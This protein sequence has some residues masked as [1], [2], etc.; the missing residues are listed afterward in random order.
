[1]G[2]TPAGQTR[3]RIYQF[4][5][6]RLLRG[7]PPT[8]REVR[9]AFGFRSIQ[10]AREHLEAL[11]A[12]GRLAKEKGK[13]RGYRL[14]SESGLTHL[15]PL[16]GRVPA[17]PLDLATED[18]EGYLPIQSHRPAD[19]LFGLRVRGESM[20]GAGILPGDMVVVRRQS[21]SDS[22]DIVV[23]LIGGEATVKRLRIRRNRVELHPENPDFEPIIPDPREL[24]LLGKVIEVRRYLEGP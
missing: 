21:T 2:R 4:V 24:T 9:D 10:T 20:T 13:A 8:V 18:L 3:E 5:R 12:E 11:V 15:V 16:L 7:F 23:A 14:G 17:G 22:G 19:D 6:D 1:M